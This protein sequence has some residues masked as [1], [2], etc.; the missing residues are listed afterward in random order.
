MIL[1][2]HWKY[3]CEALP[4]IYTTFRHAS[5]YLEFD[6]KRTGPTSIAGAFDN[7]YMQKIQQE[8]L[9]SLRRCLRGAENFVVY[10]INDKELADSVTNEVQE[11]PWSNV[12]AW[13]AQLENNVKLAKAAREKRKLLEASGAFEYILEQLRL[14]EEY[15]RQL[16]YYAAYDTI[17]DEC[18]L[19]IVQ[20]CLLQWQSPPTHTS[21]HWYKRLSSIIKLHLPASGN[22]R[23][24][25]LRALH[26]LYRARWRRLQWTLSCDYNDLPLTMPLTMVS[27]L[28][29]ILVRAEEEDSEN[30]EIMEEGQ[31]LLEMSGL[32]GMS[33][34]ELAAAL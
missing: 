33:I 25:R 23:Q 15:F 19:G 12:P 6:P 5:Y 4:Y 22:A 1:G 30:K 32:E 20:C 3:F 27:D 16:D 11:S 24:P 17:I 31:K 8:M 10:A 7:P 13:L 28:A 21:E 26:H 34:R 18:T 2:R 9:K 29:E 14:V